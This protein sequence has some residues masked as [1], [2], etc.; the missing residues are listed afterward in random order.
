MR[1]NP[2]QLRLETRDLNLQAAFFSSRPEEL[3]FHVI[4]TI[5][6][7]TQPVERLV[8]PLVSAGIELLVDVRRFPGSRRHPQ[9]NRD[10]LEATLAQHGIEYVHAPGLGGRRKPRSD[11]VNTGLRNAGFRGYADYMATSEFTA[12]LDSLIERARVRKTVIM[13]AE[14][15]PWRCHRSLI[16]DALVARGVEVEH[17]LPHH[18][19]QTASSAPRSGGNARTHQLTPAARIEGGHVTYPGLI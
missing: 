13:C 3:S 14:S 10:A 6:H 8:E 9:F 7:S 17:L 1:P 2:R 11:S 5:G 19:A 12:A 18:R 15:L 16:A 4:W